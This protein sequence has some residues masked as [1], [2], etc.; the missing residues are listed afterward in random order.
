MNSEEK[1]LNEA[2]REVFCPADRAEYVKRLRENA[3]KAE[4]LSEFCGVAGMTAL[5]EWKKKPMDGKIL[6]CAVPMLHR[7]KALDA[8]ARMLRESAAEIEQEGEGK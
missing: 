6:S 1:Q 7:G 2:L 3:R 8:F 5:L 4:E